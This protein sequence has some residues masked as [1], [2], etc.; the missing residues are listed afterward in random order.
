MSNS[1]HMKDL[2][3]RVFNEFREEFKK[4]LSEEERRRGFRYRGAQDIPILGKPAAAIKNVHWKAGAVETFEMIGQYSVEAG[5]IISN[6]LTDVFKHRAPEFMWGEGDEFFRKSQLISKVLFGELP[7][8]TTAGNWRV[9]YDLA[10]KVVYDEKRKT[11][12]FPKQKDWNIARAA[13]TTLGQA[14]KI[15]RPDGT[16]GLDAFGYDVKVLPANDPAADAA[17][18]R[19]YNLTNEEVLYLKNGGRIFYLQG[20]RNPIKYLPPDKDKPSA[21]VKWWNS[22]W[23]KEKKSTKWRAYE[24]PGMLDKIGF[25]VG[26]GK[27]LRNKFDEKFNSKQTAEKEIYKNIAGLYT[28]KLTDKQYIKRAENI[29]KE[30]IKLGNELTDTNEDPNVSV[31]SQELFLAL[32]KAKKQGAKSFIEFVNKNKNKIIAAIDKDLE[33]NSDLRVIFMNLSEVERDAYQIAMTLKSGRKTLLQWNEISD[34]S[35]IH[36]VT[37]KNYKK[38]LIR[39]NSPI[40]QRVLAVLKKIYYISRPLPKELNEKEGETYFKDTLTKLKIGGLNTSAALTRLKQ[41][42]DLA[43]SD[44]MTLRRYFGNKNF[45]DQVASA[46]KRSEAFF[47]KYPIAPVRTATKIVLRKDKLV[48]RPKLKR[49]SKSKKT[50]GQSSQGGVQTPQLPPVDPK[51]MNLQPGMP[52]VTISKAS[53]PQPDLGVPSTL[54]QT[55]AGREELEKER[56]RKAAAAKKAKG[57]KGSQKKKKINVKKIAFIGDSI[58]R[59]TLGA[60]SKIEGIEYVSLAEIGASIGKIRNSINKIPEDARIV[61]VNGGINNYPG[62]SE[63]RA[64]VYKDKSNKTKAREGGAKVTYVIEQWQ[65]IINNLLKKN[66]IV[67]ILPMTNVNKRR[68]NS[69]RKAMFIKMGKTSWKYKTLKA[70]GERIMTFASA[71]FGINNFLRRQDR[72]EKKIYMPIELRKDDAEMH[73]PDGKDGLHFTNEGYKRIAVEVEKQIREIISS[74]DSLEEAKIDESGAEIVLDAVNSAISELPMG[75]KWRNHEFAKQILSQTVEI[76]GQAQDFDQEEV[77]NIVNK[78]TG[79]I[80]VL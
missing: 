15:T 63:K 59:G 27:D 31:L 29:Q 51:D 72:A 69:K 65:I 14:D 32:K 42:K 70:S 21:F 8:K 47:K 37:D 6:S 1:E 33:K 53:E 36:F 68:L 13:K 79:G 46:I 17:S 19:S 11:L 56:R 18:G 34:I 73:N 58:M 2:K 62:F 78:L 22:F 5:R 77:E 7:E 57:S 35:D 39:P 25:M 20:Q 75:H 44:I 3:E 67:I 45:G 49:T 41:M 12:T 9:L 16:G 76:L 55:A 61:V 52:G 54:D 60:M 38:V 10:G 66:K 50:A 74:P 48:P 24:P 28:Q 26:L 40:E 80:S 4:N 71:R 23:G 43:Q 30:L 64:V